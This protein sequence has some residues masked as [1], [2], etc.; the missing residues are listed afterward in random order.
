MWRVLAGCG[1]GRGRSLSRHLCGQVAP[2]GVSGTYMGHMYMT[3]MG[4]GS[5]HL[6]GQVAPAG[7]SGTYMGHMYMTYMGLGR[8]SSRHLCGP[9]APAGMYLPPHMKCILLIRN[10]CILLLTWETLKPSSVWPSG[11]SRYVGMY[12]CMHVCM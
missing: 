3:Y 4:R 8:S 1:G 11:S 5:R 9:L 12:V 7:I 2:A 6:C 10:A